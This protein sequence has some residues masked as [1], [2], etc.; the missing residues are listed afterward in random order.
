MRL[1]FSFSEIL[2]FEIIYLEALV[3][4]ANLKLSLEKHLLQ[5]ESGNAS[6]A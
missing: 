4:K 3:W 5:L 6:L 2:D 1:P